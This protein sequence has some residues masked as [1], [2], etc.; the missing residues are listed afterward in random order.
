MA[1]PSLRSSGVAVCLLLAGCGSTVAPTSGSPANEG[2]SVGTNGAGAVGPSQPGASTNIGGLSPSTGPGV[3]GNTAGGPG[4]GA[5]ATAAGGQRPAGTAKGAVSATTVTVGYTWS[6]DQQKAANGLGVQG[7]IANNPPDE[8]AALVKQIN[9]RGGVVGHKINLYGYDISTAQE[10]QNPQATEQAACTSFTQDHH[11][12]AVLDYGYSFL[13]QCLAQ[14]DVPSITAGALIDMRDLRTDLEIDAAGPLAE[15]Y[16][17]AFI[18]R[19]AAQHYFT[20]WDTTNSR[21][22]PFPVKIGLIYEDLPSV[23]AY[24]ALVKKALAHYGYKVD[25]SD[26]VI[27]SPDASSLA[28]ANSNAVLKF[29]GDG[30]THVFGAALFFFEAAQSQHYFPR[31]SFD[32]Q[33]PAAV[34]AASAP[35][36][37]FHGALGT[38]WMPTADVAQ[39]QDPG[40]PS[41]AA[42]KCRAVIRSTGTQ[43]EASRSTLELSYIECEQVWTLA[44]ALKA[45]GALTV[46]GL[47]SGLATLGTVPSALTFSEHWDANR[48]AGAGVVADLVFNDSCNCFKY[49]AART[50]F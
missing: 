7:K 1:R 50:R 2:L 39:G 34:E 35:T 33:V 47:F 5:G 21:P 6:S 10:F 18:A 16:A 44:D 3:V 22:G 42:G 28:A 41:P 38:G 9:D 23:R 36:T 26:E 46:A 40:D 13:A 17:P 15:A 27:Y 4:Q 19:L 8:Y 31:Y 11:V 48:L 32:G 29:R 20:G 30:V 24:Y 37:Q 14:H 25:P 43:P 12:F 45:G 49:T